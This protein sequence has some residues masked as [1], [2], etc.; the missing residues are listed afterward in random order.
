VG[1]PLTDAAPALGEAGFGVIVPAQLTAS[2]QRR[3]RL[4]MRVGDDEDVELAPARKGTQV[5]GKAS[6]GGAARSRRRQGEAEARCG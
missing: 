6:N 5:A 3:L 1:L 2:G 4:R